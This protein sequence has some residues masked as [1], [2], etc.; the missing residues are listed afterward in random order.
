MF[1][2]YID[3]EKESLQPW[4]VFPGITSA[5]TIHLVVPPPQKKQI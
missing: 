3:M 1:K 5:P 2:N 4:S